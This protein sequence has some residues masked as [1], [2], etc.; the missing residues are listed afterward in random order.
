MIYYSF[1]EW[2][3]KVKNIDVSTLTMATQSWDKYLDEYNAYKKENERYIST[4]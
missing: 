2:M 3:D 1:E 4:K